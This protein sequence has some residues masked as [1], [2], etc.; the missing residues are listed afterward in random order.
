MTVH[1]TMHNDGSLSGYTDGPTPNRPPAPPPPPPSLFP[2]LPP[3]RVTGSPR[4][5]KE[6]SGGALFPSTDCNGGSASPGQSAAT[7]GNL[8]AQRPNPVVLEPDPRGPL[9]WPWRRSRRLLNGVSPSPAAGSS[10]PG[11]KSA[12]C[13]GVPRLGVGGGHCSGSGGPGARQDGL[14]RLWWQ[15]PV[16]VLAQWAAAG[17]LLLLRL[18]GLHLELS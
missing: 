10:S 4:M 12:R 18:W 14:R 16:P 11:P 6:G 15:R 1:Q 8:P 2:L 3:K 5:R 17:L 13:S 9:L 7:H